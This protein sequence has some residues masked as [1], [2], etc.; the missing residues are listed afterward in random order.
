MRHMFAWTLLLAAPAHADSLSL[1]CGQ[2]FD[3]AGGH[4]LGPHVVEIVDGRIATVRAGEPEIGSAY[5]DHRDSACIP[6]L[7]DLHTHLGNLESRPESY[8]EGFRLNPADFAIRSTLNARRTLRAGFTT[9]RDLGE[10]HGVVTAL[11][12]AINQGLVE[13]PRILTSGKSIAT[14][15]GHADPSNGRG[16]ELMGDPGP[17]EGVINGADEARKAVRQ[18]YKEGADVIKV[19]ATGGVL[20][21]A[22]NGL[23][24]QFTQAE[25]DAV[26]ATASDYGFAVAA[27]AHGKE[28][29]RRAILAGVVSIEHGTFMDEEIFRLMKERGTW[30]VPT[31]MAGWWVATRAEQEGYYPPMVAAKARVA[32]PQMLQTFALAVRAGVPIA[33]GTDSGV[34]PHGMNAREFRLMIDAGMAPAAAL[35]AATA[36]AA[37]VLGMEAELGRIAP[38]MHADLVIVERDPLA[39][40]SALER[41]RVTYKAGVAYAAEER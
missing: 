30:F 39:D 23:N 13:G 22:R 35:Q 10:N 24:P 12:D 17:R 9:V 32:G 38:G 28:G 31:L 27:H 37:R 14:T 19:T 11:R 18:R 20:S 25:L 8:S 36:N 16:R 15:G 21:Y 41:P 29:M 2:L 7:I 4:M 5:H 40:M 6:G 1:A 34:S 33:F 3:A 26:V